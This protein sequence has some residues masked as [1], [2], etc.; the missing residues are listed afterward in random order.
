VYK[1]GRQISVIEVKNHCFFSSHT[2]FLI[3]NISYYSSLLIM[4]NKKGSFL[5]DPELL[6]K[7]DKLRDLNISQHVPLPQVSLQRYIYT[8]P[9]R[10]IIG[11]YMI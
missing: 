8:S 1:K 3:N 7:I 5:S 4:I 2:D 11:S 6:E 10:F 9:L